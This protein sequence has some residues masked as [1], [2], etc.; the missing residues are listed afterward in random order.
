MLS[1]TGTRWNLSSLHQKHWGPPKLHCWNIE[2]WW[3]R[4]TYSIYWQSQ[5]FLQGQHK[6]LL[7]LEEQGIRS[8]MSIR[9]I[10]EHLKWFVLIWFVLQWSHYPSPS[11]LLLKAPAVVLLCPLKLLQRPQPR[12][13]KDKD[14]SS[15]RPCIN[16]LLNCLIQTISTLP[17]RTF[18]TLEYWH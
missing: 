12:H 8:L 4:K 7:E 5:V 15:P 3:K 13:C 18:V 16:P 6:F 11:P 17:A 14:I 10:I 9:H 2:L 1:I